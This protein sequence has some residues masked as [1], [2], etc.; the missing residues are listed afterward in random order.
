[1]LMKQEV[2]NSR[3]RAIMEEKRMN[4]VSKRT[5][6]KAKGERISEKINGG[7]RLRTE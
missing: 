7:G 6:T 3:N 1:M 4:G 2:H 5:L